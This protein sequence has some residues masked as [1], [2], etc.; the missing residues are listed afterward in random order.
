MSKELKKELGSVEV[1]G[2]LNAIGRS[3]RNEQRDKNIMDYLKGEYDCSDD[4]AVTM[5]A[6]Q[7]QITEPGERPDFANSGRPSNAEVEQRVFEVMQLF[8]DRKNE[9]HGEMPIYSWIMCRYDLSQTQAKKYIDRARRA[10]LGVT[11]KN[12]EEL[13]KKHMEE[14]QALWQRALAKNDITNQ[15]GLLNDEA[16][17]LGIM[18]P[19]SEEE[20]RLSVSG[21]VQVFQIPDNGRARDDADS[22]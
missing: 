6:S 1:A 13:I 17:I 5:Y 20:R 19:K 7:R 11:E 21:K 3:I 16:K 8:R 4:Q 18:K 10:L 15:R 2:A 14:R 9:T 12:K 22:E